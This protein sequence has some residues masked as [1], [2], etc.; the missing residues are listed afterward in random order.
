[1]SKFEIIRY[2][3]EHVSFRLIM[4][5]RRP[6]SNRHGVGT[7]ADFKSA[8]SANSATP[9]GSPDTL[10]ANLCFAGTLDIEKPLF[11][12]LLVEFQLLVIAHTPE[13]PFPAAL[14]PSA[15]W[16][17]MLVGAVTGTFPYSLGF[18]LGGIRNLRFAV[19]GS[20]LALKLFWFHC[21][22]IVRVLS[23]ISLFFGQVHRRLQKIA[24]AP[25]VSK[26][27]KIPDFKHSVN[28]ITRGRYLTPLH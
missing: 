13:I 8:A 24:K 18:N 26:L 21:P 22:P 23:H 12:L 2:I 20:I 4:E 17:A 19:D 7:P 15:M 3:L 14:V 25:R 10:L 6:D 5:C 9:A 27:C 1:V 11:G 16:F 28:R